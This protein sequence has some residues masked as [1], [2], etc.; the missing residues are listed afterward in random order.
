MNPRA[1][2]GLLLC[3]VACG[4]LSVSD[5]QDLG[6]KF[7]REI[8]REYRFLN[9]DVVTAYVTKIGT[10][11]LRT[12]G[13]QPFEYR[14]YVVENGE[15]NAFAAPAGHIYIHTGTILRVRNVAELAGVVAHEIG[16][17]TKRHIAQNYEK[18]RAASVGRQAAVI[19]AGILGGGV[20][21]GATN[22]ATGVGFSAVLN[23]FGRD[24]EREADDFAVG[25]LPAAGY[26]PS[27]LPSFFETLI[28][29]G[30]PR[31][32]AFLSSHPAPAE[33][34]EATRAA[35]AAQDPPPGLKVDDNG[36]LEIIQ[37]RIELLTEG[38]KPSR[39]R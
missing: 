14:F 29:D 34:L 9:D 25:A 11:V 2:C 37:R 15:V 22:L 19:G 8:R 13:P 26:D 21:A 28:A 6:E 18:Q 32:P 3:L 17:V 33:R 35:I 1:A 7:E 30:G 16:H 23:S 39:R 27:G 31:A 38:A 5:E 36:R 10:D 12:L 4:T 24:A 20:A